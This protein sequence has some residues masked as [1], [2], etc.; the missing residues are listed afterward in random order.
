[1]KN[2][3]SKK[4]MQKELVEHAATPFS[5]MFDKGSLM[6]AV[7]PYLLKDQTTGKN[8]V[9]A[10][11]SYLQYGPQ[12]RP[13]QQMFPDFK[14]DLIY[15]GILL[16]R[17]QKPKE[18]QKRRTKRRAEVATPAWVCA[19]MINHCDA[20]YFGRENVFCTVNRDEHTWTRTDA[21]ITF[22][23][24]TLKRTLPWQ[25]YVDDRR[26]EITCGEAPFLVSRY[27]A[28]T[29]APIPVSDRIGILDRKLR[30][31]SENAKDEP[32]WIKW[33]EHA[34]QASYG[35]EYQGDNLFFARVNLVQT[36][37]DYYEERWGHQPGKSIVRTIAR[38]VSWNLWQMDGFTDTVP[39]GIPE[40]ADRKEDPSGAGKE[41]E[42][43][44]VYAVIREWR[45][46]R[47]TE[48]RRI[49]R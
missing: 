21:R 8:I 12:Y 26:I 49:K 45:S 43:E 48:F 33:A 25:R 15:K 11:D 17:A 13:E 20:D 3:E 14:P 18:M 38:I 37:I 23:E 31:V 10:T 35:Y 36:F 34:Y 30:V 32:E 47:T 16:P 24:S 2:I 27:D 44:P 19:M 42:P 41:K 39:Y 6:Y 4:R 28:V 22:P 5:K 40:N 46:K 29:G 1:M 7:L 9:W